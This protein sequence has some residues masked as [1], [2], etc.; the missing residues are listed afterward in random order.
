MLLLNAQPLLQTHTHLDS[1]VMP[2]WLCSG[3]RAR[4]GRQKMPMLTRLS[5]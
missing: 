3:M 5:S 2:G 1:T 4:A